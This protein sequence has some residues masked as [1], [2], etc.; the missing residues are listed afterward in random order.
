M[1]R[2]TGTL[3]RGFFKGRDEISFLNIPKEVINNIIVD[4]VHAV[5]I[6]MIM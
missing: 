2:Y 1:R 4:T 3:G 5:C 6:I